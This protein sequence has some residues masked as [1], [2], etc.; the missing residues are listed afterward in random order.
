MAYRFDFMMRH[1][2]KNVT[3]WAMGKTLV[4]Q[5][6]FLKEVILID[7]ALEWNPVTVPLLDI[8]SQFSV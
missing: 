2:D 4:D 5:N 3:G 7:G 6:S 1:Q 8:T